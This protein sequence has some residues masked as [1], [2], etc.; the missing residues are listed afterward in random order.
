M[1]SGRSEGVRGVPRV[2]E[3]SRVGS[4]REDQEPA[5]SGRAGLAGQ[6]LLPGPQ[7]SSCR[8]S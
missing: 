8:F 2:R 7:L 5:G 1:G 3:G 4:S 6:G